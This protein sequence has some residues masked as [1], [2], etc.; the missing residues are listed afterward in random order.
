VTTL[1]GNGTSGFADG[2][3]TAARFS[4]LMGVAV[5]ATGNV[6]VAD[7]GNNRIRKIT[8]DGVVTT[9]GGTGEPVI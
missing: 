9:I 6:Y 8:S 3:G 1:A 2:I 4:I 5:D 7:L